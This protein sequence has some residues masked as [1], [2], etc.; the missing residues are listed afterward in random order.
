MNLTPIIEELEID[1]LPEE[2]Q[3]Q[4]LE[5]IGRALYMRVT[6]RLAGELTEGQLEQVERAADE[7]G[8][9]AALAMME[10]VYPQY[11]QVVQEELEAVKDGIK[12]LLGR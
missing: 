7:Q 12:A 10:R 5:N 11:Q 3:L 8:A 9:D 2:E 1:K 4:V 6:R